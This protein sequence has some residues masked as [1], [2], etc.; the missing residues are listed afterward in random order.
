MSLLLYLS[1]DSLYTLEE[2]RILDKQVRENH[3]SVKLKTKSNT[4]FFIF[5]LITIYVS[6]LNTHDKIMCASSFLS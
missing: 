1:Y 6:W 5:K 2:K 4:S 3:N